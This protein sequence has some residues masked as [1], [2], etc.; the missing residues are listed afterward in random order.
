MGVKLI[1]ALL[2]PVALLGLAFS[3]R[4]RSWRGVRSTSVA[5][6][7]LGISVA[8]LWPG[9]WDPL[10]E[11]G[12][13]K[14]L[15]FDTIGALLA[16]LLAMLQSITPN[17]MLPEDDPW[18]LAQVW[19]WALFVPFWL[20]AIAGSG[21]L[22]WRLRARLPGVLLLPSAMVLLGYHVLFTMVV[23]PWHFITVICLSLASST[24]VGLLSAAAITVSGLLYYLNDFWVWQVLADNYPARALVMV[25]TLLGGPSLALCLMAIHT[26]LQTRRARG[27]QSEPPDS[28][29]LSPD[30][31][32]PSLAAS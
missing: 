6:S 13:R 10:L 22:A 1:T 27:S 8:A 23:L 4:Q 18:E 9:V 26:W 32:T 12:V 16:P 15:D 2:I 25:M 7:L 21:V 31:L 30:R 11:N 14:E 3:L 24:R 5:L 20:A 19:R 29:N 28:P 17:W